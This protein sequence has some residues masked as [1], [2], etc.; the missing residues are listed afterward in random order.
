MLAGRLT[1]ASFSIFWF[2]TASHRIV[3]ESKM[4]RRI[5]AGSSAQQRW[6]SH[7][8]SHNKNKLLYIYR[9]VQL[10]VRRLHSKRAKF[11][12]KNGMSSVMV[13]CV[14]IGHQYLRNR[15]VQR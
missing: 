7:R 5:D 12:I 4:L 13:L 11:S 2:M 14:Q 6:Q 1:R 10:A 15:A 9:I 8:S 3:I